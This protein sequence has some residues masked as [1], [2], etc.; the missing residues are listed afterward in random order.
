MYS[1]MTLY[2]IVG[3]WSASEKLNLSRTMEVIETDGTLNVMAN[4]TFVVTMIQSDP[5]VMLK[6]KVTFNAHFVK[7]I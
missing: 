7:D 6:Q 2:I 4:K 1:V 5:Y 3:T